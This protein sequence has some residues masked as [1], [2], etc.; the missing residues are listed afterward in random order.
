MRITRVTV[1]AGISRCKDYQT[2]KCE[3]QEEVEI[4]EGDDCQAIIKDVKNDLFNQVNLAT[5]KGLKN[6]LAS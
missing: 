5:I 3:L 6:V 2:V 1:T 4:D